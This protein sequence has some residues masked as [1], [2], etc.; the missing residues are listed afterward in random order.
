[1]KVPK[2]KIILRKPQKC[3]SIKRNLFSHQNNKLLI[4]RRRHIHTYRL[5]I[6]ERQHTTIYMWRARSPSISNGYTCGGRARPQS[7]IH[8][9]VAGALAL[10]LKF[11]HM[12]RAHSPSISKL[13]KLADQFHNQGF[14][15]SVNPN[16]C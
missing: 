14:T 11:I 9:H 16:N 3:I 5:I 2:K 8:T 15:L 1:M 13:A 7:Q 6:P 4:H 10:N 12:W